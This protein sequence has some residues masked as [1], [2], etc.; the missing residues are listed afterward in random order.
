[1]IIRKG[2]YPVRT[3]PNMMG[4]TGEFIL[5]DILQPEQ[6]H[7]KGRLFARGTLLPGHSVGYHVHENDMEICV[8][9]EGRGYVLDETGA[10]TEISAGD[11]QIVD[12][13]QGHAIV[14][15][16]ETPLVYMA[17]VLYGK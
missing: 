5:E 12:A 17:V 9:L 2:N 11:T 1:M 4:G 7:E 16:A 3:I 13:G 14:N 10:K 15:D 6:M 8:F